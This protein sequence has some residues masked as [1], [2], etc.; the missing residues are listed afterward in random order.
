MKRNVS[1]LMLADIGVLPHD[2][3]DRIA[4]WVE[5]GGVLVRFAGP[6]LEK[7]GDDLLPV[8]LRHG[9]RSLGGALSWSTP[10]PLAPFGEES[11]FAGLPAPPCVCV[12]TGARSG[13]GPDRSGRV[14]VRHVRR[15]LPRLT[16]STAFEAP[17]SSTH[18]PQL[19]QVS[20]GS[21]RPRARRA[22]TK[23]FVVGCS[24]SSTVVPL[25]RL[26]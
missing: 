21:P 16:P 11:L 8:A 12:L 9:G 25:T 17:R 20:L 24:S 26:A 13:R 6:R 14:T 18:R 3:H 19:T 15:W 1:A 22:L 2:V 10:Q 5:K 4:D 23:S 7:G